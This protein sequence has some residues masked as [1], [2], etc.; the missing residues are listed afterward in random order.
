MLDIPVQKLPEFVDEMKR[1]MG[2]TFCPSQDHCL[3]GHFEEFE[4]HRN[5]FIE[6]HVDYPILVQELGKYAVYLS[7]FKGDWGND[8]EFF[9]LRARLNAPNPANV[10]GVLFE[11]Q[12]AFHFTFQH[13]TVN[14][15]PNIGSETEFDLSVITM[16]GEEV[17]VECTRRLPRP[18]RANDPAFLVQEVEVSVNFK[19]EKITSLDRPLWIAVL[20]PETINWTDGPSKELLDRKFDELFGLTEYSAI[21]GVIVVS[22]RK[23]RLRIVDSAVSTYVDDLPVYSYPNPKAAHPVPK[24][25][26]W[27]LVRRDASLEAHKP[28]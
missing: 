23:P 12:A 24:D 7:L 13:S 5:R 9:A 14:W 6:G 2:I 17:L 18:R 15:L 4:C 21:A 10:F 3:Y 28:I 20:L 1:L 25:F 22:H 27:N 26:Y 19:R 16:S 8:R 11:F